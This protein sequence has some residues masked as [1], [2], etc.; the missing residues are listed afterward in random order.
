MTYNFDPDRWL[1]DQQRLLE[2]RR[3]RGELGEDAYQ[4][5]LRDVERRHDALVA[6]LDRTFQLVPPPKAPGA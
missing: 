1:E 5:A 4:E 2:M 6:R 3:A